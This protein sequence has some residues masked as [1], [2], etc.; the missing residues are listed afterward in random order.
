MMRE[1]QRG[2][3]RLHILHRADD[4]E[5]GGLARAEAERRARIEFGGEEKFRAQS[6]EQ[7]GGHLLET[8]AQDLRYSLRVLRRK[9]GFAIAA[10]LRK[11]R[12]GWLI[13]SGILIGSIGGSPRLNG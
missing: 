7:R 10:V 12:R 5:R 3:V 11:R 1:F 4:L 13:S 8:F 6:Y 9:P 2:A